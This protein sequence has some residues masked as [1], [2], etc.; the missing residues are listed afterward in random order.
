MASLLYK[1][2]CTVVFGRGSGTCSGHCSL[3]CHW[4][5]AKMPIS[6]VKILLTVKYVV[7]VTHWFQPQIPPSMDESVTAAYQKIELLPRVRCGVLIGRCT[8]HAVGKYI[9]RMSVGLLRISGISGT[10]VDLSTL[11]CTYRAALIACAY[12]I[13]ME[14]TTRWK[15]DRD[16]PVT[17]VSQD[18][19]TRDDCPGGAI[20]AE[21][22]WLLAET[23]NDLA[24]SNNC[25]NYVWRLTYAVC[26]L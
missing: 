13:R 15:N 25:W 16:S 12:V 26:L 8:H 9:Q 7:P 22:Q 24:V 14:P 5:F 21:C 11:H 17:C 3:L 18:V 20:T 1:G 6:S 10:E 23:R 19:W 2:G 4:K